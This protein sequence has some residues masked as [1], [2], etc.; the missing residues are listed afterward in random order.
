MPPARDWQQ[1]H[2]TL[3]PMLLNPEFLSS[4]KSLLALVQRN[5][6]LVLH[7]P[8]HQSQQVVVDMAELTFGLGR[9]ICSRHGGGCTTCANM[10]VLRPRVLV[11]SGSGSHRCACL[12]D[13]D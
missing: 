2:Q 8:F 7:A 11:F 4:L 3:L 12:A 5:K 13:T 6:R 1:A 10:G 9:A